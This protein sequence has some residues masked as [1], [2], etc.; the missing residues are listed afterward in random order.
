MLI[1]RRSECEKQFFPALIE[2]GKNR[3]TRRRDG[4]MTKTGTI[5]RAALVLALM[6]LL[7]GCAGKKA[8]SEF[9]AMDTVMQIT[10]YGK[11]ADAAVKICESE[12][13]RL[14]AKLSAQSAGSEIAKLNAGG[15]CQ[16]D[17][18]LRLLSEALEI[19]RKT[20]G[21][22]DPTVY[23]LMKLWGF[24]TENAHVPQNSEI[25]Q[26]LSC[27]GYE[28]LPGVKSP[29]RLPEGMAVDLGGIGKGFAASVARRCLLDQGV[30]SAVLSLGGNVTLIGSKIDGSDWTVG[31][32]DPET[33]SC[34]G[35]VSG[36]AVS[37]VTA[38]GYQRY[39]EE[40]GR[41]YW[42][43]L[44]AKTGWPA[45]TGLSSVTIVSADD[46][47]ADGLSPALFVMGLEK[48]IEFWRESSGFEAVFLLESG[49]IYVTQGLRGSFRSERSFEVIAR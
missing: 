5:A 2:A 37:V 13:A 27:V 32:Q 45:E 28:K 40:N 39:F 18:T 12:I 24:G 35:Y 23:P 43:I 6:T 4:N 7:S 19:A 34:F 16:D 20:N 22:Y 11:H 41:R 30:S 8:A 42:H 44:N 25:E 26:E 1:G 3:M 49:E 38:G 21:A 48:G 9:F 33:D 17:E 36:T 14:D 47:L 15:V 31:L 10:A 46:T 29:Y